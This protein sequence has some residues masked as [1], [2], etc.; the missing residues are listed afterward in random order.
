[1]KLIELVNIIGISKECMGQITYEFLQVKKLFARFFN[2]VKTHSACE[3][4]DKLKEL[5]YKLVLEPDSQIC[6]ASGK[7]LSLKSN[8]TTSS[9]HGLLQ[10]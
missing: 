9:Y 8:L 7:Q 2:M 5:S 3:M 10:L 1:M 4:T 6:M